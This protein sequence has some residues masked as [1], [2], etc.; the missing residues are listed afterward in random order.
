M[1]EENAAT[2]DSG[3]VVFKNINWKDMVMRFFKSILN[4]FKSFLLKRIA[5]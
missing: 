2:L 3:N 5:A 4:F 1:K